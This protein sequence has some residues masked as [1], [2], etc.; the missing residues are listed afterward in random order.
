MMQL[1]PVFPSLVNNTSPYVNVIFSPIS[2]LRFGA[3]KN[4]V[5]KSQFL[6]KPFSGANLRAFERRKMAELNKPN[7]L[8]QGDGVLRDGYLESS[9]A[10]SSSSLRSLESALNKS[11]KWLAAALFGLMI[12]W[13]H[14]A[15]VLWAAMGSVINA[16]ISVTLKR[17]LNHERPSGLRSDPG[18]PSSHAQSMFYISVFAVLSLIQWLGFNFWSLPLG[19]VILASGSYFSWLRVSQQLHTTNQVLVGALLGTVISIAWF[20]LWHACL[21]D[22]FVSS[23]WVRIIVVLGSISFCAAFVIYVAQ[24]WLSDER[25]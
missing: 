17:I 2:F 8:E 25:I 23:I 13:K 1:F 12:L 11:S 20:W 9:S 4:R 5:L 21:Y 18:M 14:D 10:S 24:N 22:A 15:E 16:W 19:A 7:A 6:L 3:S